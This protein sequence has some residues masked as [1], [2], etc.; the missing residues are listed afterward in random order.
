MHK[1]AIIGALMVLVTGATALPVAGDPT[2]DITCPSSNGT[3]YAAADGGDFDIECFVDHF[4]GDLSLAWTNSFAS[5]LDTCDGTATCVAVSY[6]GSACYM[7]SEAIG[8]QSNSNVWGAVKK[9]TSSS[10]TTGNTCPSADGTTVTEA[11]GQ[12]FNIHCG[13]DYLGGDLSSQMTDSF[14]S[15]LTLC[16][17]TIG[18]VALS[19]VGPAPGWCYV[20]SQL[21]QPVSNNAVWA[22][23]LSAAASTT[24]TTSTTS[25]V[26]QT[27]AATSSSTPSSVTVT[28]GVTCPSS[29]GT[30][31]TEPSGQQ[32]M[33]DCFVDSFGGDLSSALTQ[34]FDA[35][36]SLCDST[37][38]CVAVSW[39]GPAP[40][41]CYMKNDLTGDL[42]TNNAVWAATLY[43]PPATPTTS[44]ASSSTPMTTSAPSSTDA[45]VASASGLTPSSVSD[46]SLGYGTVQ[47][48]ASPITLSAA[49]TATLTPMAPPNVDM[50]NPL[51]LTP[52]SVGQVWYSGNNASN[53]SGSGVTTPIVRLNLT[54]AYPSILLDQSAYITGVTCI[55]NSTLTASFTDASTYNYAK[56]T[57]PSGS[58][59]VLVTAASSCGTDGQNAFFVANAISFDDSSSTVTATGSVQPIAN[60]LQTLDMDFGSI[61]VTASNSS[62]TSTDLGCGTPNATQINSLPA[63]ACGADFDQ[64]LDDY[65]GYY[66]VDDADVASTELALAPGISG[67]NFRRHFSF[68]SITSFISKAV[69]TVVN[70]VPKVVQKIEQISPPII[71]K[72]ISTVASIASREINNVKNDIKTVE[73]IG[74]GIATGNF[75]ETWNF[76]VNLAPPEVYLTESPWGDGFKFYTFTAEGGEKFSLEATIKDELKDSVKTIEGDDSKEPGVELWCV[77]CGVTGNFQL[78]GSF[79]ASILHGFTKGQL[80]MNGNLYAGLF[81]G[82]DAFAEWDLNHEKDLFTMGLP[83][84][85]IPDIVALGPTLALGVSSDLDITAEGQFLLGASLTW[86]SISVVMNILDESQSSHSGFTPVLNTTIQSDATLTTTATLGLPVTLGFGL[87]VLNGRWNKEVKLVDTPGISA[88]C[89]LK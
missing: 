80:S 39:V 12:S 47:T 68:H 6:V 38:G 8:P 83:G 55:A 51:V 33:V 36:L 73:A 69:K 19:W 4:G 74:V 56:T 89:E 49:P 34:S 53:S 30:I 50:T 70:T 32:F 16:E 35:C 26:S 3:T 41:Y 72:A 29:N 75:K 88:T 71:S 22:A 54:L 77:N 63:M 42:R 46:A 61:T 84:L 58:L 79:S 52:Q 87:N 76:P 81:I 40:G 66:P 37:A 27:N 24:T 60:V 45:A 13:T 14:D 86:P 85:S 43:T 1:P 7:K 17:S 25:V 59:V 10:V 65:L 62:A 31:A 15:C 9:I 67:Q 20:K 5:C 64:A 11:N 21:S 78:T 28:T 23:V 2:A 48:L 44:A 57:W 18:C 82:L